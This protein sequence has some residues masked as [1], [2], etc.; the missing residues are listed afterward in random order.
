LHLVSGESG[1]DMVEINFALIKLTDEI[2]ELDGRI[3]DC[4]YVDNQCWVF[5]KLRD[6]RKYPN[7]KPVIESMKLFDF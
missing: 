3:I 6:D 1:D 2:R 5:S 4:H 7:V